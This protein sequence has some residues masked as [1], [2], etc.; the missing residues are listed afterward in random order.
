MHAQPNEHLLKMWRDRL[1]ELGY[2][3]SP[4]D[5]VA[6][7]SADEPDVREVAL[8]LLGLG[9]HRDA[10]PTVTQHLD[11]S[12]PPARAEAA[13]SVVL[14]GDE[15]GLGHLRALLESD[16]PETAIN[17][18]AYLADLGDSSG[19]SVISRALHS[20]SEAHRLQA[21]LLVRAFSPYQGKPAGDEPID[22]VSALEH[23]VTNDPSAMVRREAVYQAA[24]LPEADR[25]RLLGRASSD[26]D[27]TVAR[28]AQL[29]LEG[30]VT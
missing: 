11:D 18:A 16:W 14:L 1:S 7:A 27:A 2:S 9:G 15:A 28:A 13:R 21:A 20:R 29:R 3:T 26:P 5:L 6:A 12:Y 22:V 4:K 25:R 30:P 19:F 8:A 23:A 24:H 10:L 17:A